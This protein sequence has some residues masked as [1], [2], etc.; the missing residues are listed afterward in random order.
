MADLLRVANIECSG[1]CKLIVWLRTFP[2]LENSHD[3]F[4]TNRDLTT[5][6][7]F[8]LNNILAQTIENGLIVT[9]LH[10]IAQYGLWAALEEA[11]RS[12]EDVSL[13]HYR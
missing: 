5:N 10:G 4:T 7:I 6:G 3:F 8:S 9:V 11:V 1:F 2:L 12:F 13:E